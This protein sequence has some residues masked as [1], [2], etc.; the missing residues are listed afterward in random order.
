MLDVICDICH[1]SLQKKN[2]KKDIHD[3]AAAATQQLLLQ[4]WS[5]CLESEGRP[6][7]SLFAEGAGPDQSDQWKCQALQVCTLKVDCC[8][9]VPKIISHFHVIR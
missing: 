7:T 1:I 3:V 6:L 5:L 9:I 2:D 8:H 4:H